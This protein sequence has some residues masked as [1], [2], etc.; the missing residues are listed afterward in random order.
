MVG[1][2]LF[3]ATA[4]SASAVDFTRD[5]EPILKRNCYG[6]HGAALQQNGLRLDRADDAL[7]GSYTGPVIVPGHAASSKL[8]EMVSSGKMPKTPRKLTADQIEVLRKWID[9]GAAM[10]ASAMAVK[11][12]STHWSFQP[13]VRPVPPVVRARIRNPIDAFVLAAL[14]KK[15]VAASPEA[16]PA[17]L[18]RRVSLDLTGLPPSPADLARYLADTRPD[19]YERAVD[20]LLHS[21]HYGEKWARHWLDQAR[22]ADSDGYEKDS[23]RPWAWRWRHWVIE[24]LNADMPFDEF[25]I[26][27]LAGD[28][29]PNAAQENLAATGFLRNSLAN[30]E[31]G[32]NTEQFRVEQVMDRTATTSTVWLGLTAGCAQCHD[33]KY[34]PISQRQYYGLFAFFNALV[35]LDQPAPL[36]GEHGTWMRQW[37]VYESER[38]A[39]L[40]RYNM[41][42]LVEEWETAMR[43]VAVQAPDNSRAQFA[44]KNLG[45]I[46]TGLQDVVLLDRNRRSRHLHDQVLVY[47]VDRGASD[48]FL[49]D[50][51]GAAKFDEF[52]KAFRETRKKAPPV[53]LA[54]TVH[55][56]WIPRQTHILLR[57]DFR[58]PGVAVEPHTPAVLPPLPAGAPPTRLTLARWLVSGKHPLTARVAVNRAWQEFF[59]RG[60][61]RTSEDFGKQGEPPSHPE[62]LDWLAAEFM[63]PKSARP[64]SIKALHRLIV[65]SATYRQS[66]KSR[67]GLAG[68]DPDNTWIARQSRI[69]LPAELIRDSALAASGLLNPAVGGPSIRPPQPKGVAELAYAG[70]VKWNESTGPDRYKRGLYIHF[71]RTTPY[72]QLT[73]FDAPDAAVACSRRQRSYT[74][75]QALNLLNDAVFF[76]AAQ[77]LGIRLVQEV[78]S[79]FRERLIRGFRL[80]LNRDPAEK[81]VESLA[82][83]FERELLVLRDN[84]R[85]VQSL[86]PDVLDRAGRLETAGWVVISRVLLNLDEFLHRE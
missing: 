22:Y 59:G 41:H 49:K 31:G 36:P 56:N 47:F 70:S 55:E 66:S 68:R 78:P 13:I 18:L 37:P 29:L 80:T 11:T 4:A 39:L 79:G 16:P 77:A 75:L 28:L 76:E 46:A 63:Q 73:N 6:C 57:G 44:W 53:T 5:I 52:K 8:I 54:Q 17:T 23:E 12:S 15:G 67:P 33:H 19:A 7:R 64:W 40:I 82:R 85:E 71:Q 24:A 10:P 60:L 86:A 50:R 65:T 9:A 81:E 58:N 83:H 1:L 35:N 20:M 32:V 30:R 3:V 14:G 61:V 48:L 38:E 51:L 69:R 21:P 45:N 27:Q 72:P 74:P 43:T 42:A 84:P 26:E 62:L 34:D 25:T 2:L